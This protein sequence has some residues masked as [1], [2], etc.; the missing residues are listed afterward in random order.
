MTQQV[1]HARRMSAPMLVLAASLRVAA[2]PSFRAESSARS[3]RSPRR[4]NRIDQLFS[5]LP[6]QALPMTRARA[7]PP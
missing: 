3:C 4:E 7:S 5:S 1:Q 2:D 6:S